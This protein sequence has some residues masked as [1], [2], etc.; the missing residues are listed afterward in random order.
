M[1]SAVSSFPCRGGKIPCGRKQVTY[2][3]QGKEKSIFCLVQCAFVCSF[4]CLLAFFLV[5][6]VTVGISGVVVGTVGDLDFADRVIRY[7]FLCVFRSCANT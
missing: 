4:V 7:A 5:V 1:S 6:V 3:R 2:L